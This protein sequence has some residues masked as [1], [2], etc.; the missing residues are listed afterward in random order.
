M[1]DFLKSVGHLRKEQKPNYYVLNHRAL[2]N[3]CSDPT[4]LKDARDTANVL[5]ENGETYY[6]VEL[7]EIVN[8]S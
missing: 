6:V 3:A 4:G 8:N 2:A 5:A 7:L 1:S